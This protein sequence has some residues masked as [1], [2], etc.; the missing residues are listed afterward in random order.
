MSRSEWIERCARHLHQRCPSIRAEALDALA[1]SA[2]YDHYPLRSPEE[3][4]RGIDLCGT[5]PA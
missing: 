4:A 3:A 2:W 5:L 1:R